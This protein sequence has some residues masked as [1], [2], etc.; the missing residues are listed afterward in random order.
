MVMVLEMVNFVSVLVG[1]GS[2]VVIVVLALPDT[3]VTAGGVMV[4]VIVVA[5]GTTIVDT[6]PV[7]VTVVEMAE[8]PRVVEV[9]R[10]GVRLARAAAVGS[11]CASRPQSL[12]LPQPAWARPS[13]LMREPAECPAARA[14]ETRA[15]VAV[16]VGS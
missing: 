2:V 15:G 4:T 5:V 3:L 12:L 10:S 14:E 9:Q 1:V 7:A 6:G 16:A 8:V 11:G 13:R